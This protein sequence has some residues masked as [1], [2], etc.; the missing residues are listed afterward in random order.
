MPD[1]A[2][3]LFA[4]AILYGISDLSGVLTS[5][6]S[7]PLA[8][9]YSQAT[10][11]N[12]GAT[13]G[14]LLIVYLSLT[15]CVIGTILTVARIWWTLAR[16]NATPFSK[17]FSM[18]DEKRSCPIPATLFCGIISTGLGA[19]PLGSVTAFQDLAGSFIIL[20]TTS[21]VLAIAPNALTGR[22]NI[23][24]GPFTLGRFGIP[25][26]VAA[27]V[28]IIFF[29]IMFCFRESTPLAVLS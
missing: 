9:I 20:T 22:K 5:N 7:F 4:I 16:D 27:V 26:N 2:S 25:L 12:A 6:G 23:P 14:L 17:F 10:N 3:F 21:F 15:I 24:P 8:A 13:F 29:N 28:L 1:P 11:G 18:V 19:I